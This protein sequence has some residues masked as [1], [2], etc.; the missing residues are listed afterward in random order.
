VIE[1][2]LHADWELQLQ[3]TFCISETEICKS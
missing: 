3:W 1:T 2:Y